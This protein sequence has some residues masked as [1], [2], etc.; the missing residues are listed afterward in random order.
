M[1]SSK[2]NPQKFRSFSEEGSAAIL[3]ATVPFFVVGLLLTSCARRPDPSTL[4]M[5]IESSPV[6]LDPRVGIDAQSERFDSLIFDA[7]VHRDDHFSF[8]PSLA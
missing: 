2:T 4:V 5:I 1:C 6:N 8:T 7:L 3:R